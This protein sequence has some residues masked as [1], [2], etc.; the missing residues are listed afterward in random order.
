MKIFWQQVCKKRTMAIIVQHSIWWDNNA[1][2]YIEQWWQT[3]INKCSLRTSLSYQ[4]KFRIIHRMHTN[5]YTSVIKKQ[6]KLQIM[7][8]MSCVGVGKGGVS[9]S[10]FYIH[11]DSIQGTCVYMALSSLNKTISY[12]LID[13]HLDNANERNLSKTHFHILLGNNFLM[14]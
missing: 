8:K 9:R 13:K 3:D 4:R 2:E 5:I 12:F 10:Q 1:S 7:G 6:N 14:N 11:T